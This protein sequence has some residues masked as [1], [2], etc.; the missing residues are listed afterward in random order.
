[1]RRIL[2]PNFVIENTKLFK[3]GNCI[4]FF[5]TSELTKEWNSAFQQKVNAQKEL[6]NS[7]LSEYEKKEVQFLLEKIKS[8]SKEEKLYYL[9][10]VKTKTEA[11]YGVEL[12]KIDATLPSMMV[13]YDSFW[14]KNN[15][16]WFNTP[17]LNATIQSFAGKVYS[18]GN[19]IL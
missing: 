15:P 12:E 17:N 7:Q 14:P 1:M 13:E 3:N 9:H 10:L 4:K 2:N 11:L 5:S 8:L 6:L 18:G 16:N 19:F